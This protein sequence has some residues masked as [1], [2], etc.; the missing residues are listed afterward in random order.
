M[1]RKLSE[2]DQNTTEAPIVKKKVVTDDWVKSHFRD[3]LLK[4]EELEAQTEQY[5]KS[6]P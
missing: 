6:K 5:S 1:K 3:G 4:G 2:E